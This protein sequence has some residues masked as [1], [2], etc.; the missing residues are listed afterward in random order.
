MKIW[1]DTEY[2]YRCLADKER[3]LA[4]QSAIEAVVKSGMVVLDV[5][6]GSGIMSIFA[7][8]CGAS[9][10]YAIEVGRYLSKVSKKIFS[11]SEFAERIIPLQL[12][13]SNLNLTLVEKPDVVICEQITTGLIGEP[14]GPVINALKRSGIVDTRTILIP[15]QFSTTIE[16]V[17][18]DFNFYGAELKFPVFVDYFSKRFDSRYESL[19]KPKLAHTVNFSEVY[20]ERVVIKELLHSSE[21]GTVNGVLLTSS[22]RFADDGELGTCISYAQPV[23]LPVDELTINKGAIIEVEITYKMGQ[24]F[25]S[26]DY[27]IGSASESARQN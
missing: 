8:R 19:S 25:D 7:A 15:A 13:A 23:I 10:V 16:L 9:R 17:H 5:G 11:E 12:E 14:Q 1:S 24:G 18:A 2:V 20:D 3:T 4:F 22:T 21:G 26:L 27:R 6:T